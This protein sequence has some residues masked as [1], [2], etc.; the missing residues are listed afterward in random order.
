MILL[1]A[2]TLLLLIEPTAKPPKDPSTG[3]QLD[4]CRERIE[5]LL[6]TL[7]DPAVQIILP[8]PVLAEVLVRAGTARN[9]YLTEL[10]TN[11][12]FKPA[13]FDERAAVELSVILDGD[14]KSKKKLSDKQTWAKL[15]FDRQIIAIAKVHRVT[16]IYSDD[17]DL[18]KCARDNNLTVIHTWQL[19][20]PPVAAQQELE[21]T[22]PSD[23]S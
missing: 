12:V 17:A 7:S 6:Q 4:K 2:T 19:P 5:Y 8:T 18:A 1:D 3:R 16:T 13:S 15:K 10:T 22:P 9:Q 21:L 14:A 20:L 11:Y 23:K